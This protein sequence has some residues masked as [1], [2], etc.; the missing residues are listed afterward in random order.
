MHK[1]YFFINKS[2]IVL[3]IV[4]F[5]LGRKRNI[6]GHMHNIDQIVTAVSTPEEHLITYILSLDPH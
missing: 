5:P 6:Y 4:Y 2:N 3:L 1:A